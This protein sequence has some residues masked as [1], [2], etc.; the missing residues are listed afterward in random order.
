MASSPHSVPDTPRTPSPFTAEDEHTRSRSPPHEDAH[1]MATPDSVDTVRMTNPVPSGAD[2]V[3]L[4]DETADKVPKGKAKASKGPL[5]LLDLPV[6]I[7]K[8]IIHQVRRGS[9]ATIWHIRQLLGWTG[10]LTI[11]ASS[12]KR[13]HLTLSVSL[14]PAPA[15]HSMHLLAL[16]YCLARRKHPYRTALR[17]RCPHVR[18]GDAGHGR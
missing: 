1:T 2:G 12:H 6:D 4:A 11:L 8:E 15:Y 7:L 17:S 9:L 14:G 13:P 16:R 10:E 18:T 3:S 5:R